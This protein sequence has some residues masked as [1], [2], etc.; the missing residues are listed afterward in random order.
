MKEVRLGGSWHA[1]RE[2]R[3]VGAASYGLMGGRVERHS[4]HSFRTPLQPAHTSD[5]LRGYKRRWGLQKRESKNSSSHCQVWS[6][7]ERRLLNF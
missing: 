5:L 4:S 1:E 7:I 2:E 6:L 3:K